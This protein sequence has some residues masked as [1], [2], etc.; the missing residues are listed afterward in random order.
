MKRSM[1]A[2]TRISLI[3]C[4]KLTCYL[5]FLQ[6]CKTTSEKH[7]VLILN[8][9]DRFGKFGDTRTSKPF[10]TFIKVKIVVVR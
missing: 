10:S 1:V 9:F 2:L 8:V 4:C 7:S 5:S 6:T 3:N